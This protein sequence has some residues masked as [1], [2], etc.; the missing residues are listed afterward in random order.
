MEISENARHAIETMDLTEQ[1][2]RDPFQLSKGERQRVAVASVLSLKPEILILD[3]PTT[4]L[5]YRQQ[6]YLMDLLKQLNREGA[7][8]VIV[9]HTLKLVAEYCNYCVLLSGGRIQAEGNPRTVLFGSSKMKL[10]PLLE[11]SRAMNGNAVTVDEFLQNVRK[12]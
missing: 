2:E 11:L 1:T 9:T 3:E 10:P 8:V 6:K 4:G 5:D 12:R 7:T